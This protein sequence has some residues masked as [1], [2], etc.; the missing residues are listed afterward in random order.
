MT[1][2]KKTDNIDLAPG[3]LR[4]ARERRG[5]AIEEA[6]NRLNCSPAI[7]Q[8]LEEGE[9]KVPVRMLRK[10]SKSYKLP[11]TALLLPNPPAETPLPKDFRRQ[12][13]STSKVPAEPSKSLQRANENARLMQAEAISLAQELDE[14]PTMQLPNFTV[15]DSPEAAAE[16][17]RYTLGISS[18][19]QMSW[20]S[21]HAALREW[22]KSLERFSIIVFQFSDVSPEEASAFCIQGKTFPVI[23][24]NS[25]EA[26]VRRIFSLF[27]ELGHLLLGGSAL[28]L[29]LNQR[30]TGTERWCDSFAAAF[31]MPRES[32]HEKEELIISSA[33]DVRVLAARWK[34]SPL[35]MIYRLVE[36]GLI[37]RSAAEAWKSDFSQQQST[38]T[39]SGGDFWRSYMV[40]E[41]R[42]FLGLVVSAQQAKILPLHKAADLANL[43]VSKWSRL[44]RELHYD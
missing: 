24:L 16:V 30:Q 14:L 23:S 4:W 10:L 15:E 38:Q 31:L 19:I 34:V 33:E 35:A 22:R 37:T 7:L 5:W 43:K 26:P 12:R 27:H 40:R 11:F 17:L 25:K 41:S 32:F 39:V 42:L 44:L 2:G 1:A 9:S 20:T 28:C 3:V 36:V 21:P 8:G 13:A 18:E 29:V 6:S